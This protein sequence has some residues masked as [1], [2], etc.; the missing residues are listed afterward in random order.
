MTEIVRLWRQ[1]PIANQER[2]YF[3]DGR[4]YAIDVVRGGLSVGDQFD[5]STSKLTPP[6]PEL[7]RLRQFF[8]RYNS[9]V[10]SAYV[11]GIAGPAP[12]CLQALAG[13]N[14]SYLGLT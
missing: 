10:I 1:E 9:L 6:M 11:G 3:A 5:P 2:V 8:A 12:L 14:F 4:S 7:F 13:C